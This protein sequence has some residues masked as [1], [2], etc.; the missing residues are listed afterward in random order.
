MSFKED[1]QHRLAAL[2]GSMEQSP[3]R[4][5]VIYHLVHGGMILVAAGFVLAGYPWVVWAAVTLSVSLT[6]K[7]FWQVELSRRFSLV[8]LVLMGLFLIGSVAAMAWSKHRWAL[9]DVYSLITFLAGGVALILWFW[10]ADR[11][12]KVQFQL[13]PEDTG[14]W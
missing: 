12:Y 1:L 11:L 10:S 3:A 4:D 8:G 6:A 14:P 13:P 7:E 2:S 9:A 5:R